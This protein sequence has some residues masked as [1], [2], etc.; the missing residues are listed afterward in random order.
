MVHRV[1]DGQTIV[2]TGAG[3]GIGGGGLLAAAEGARVVVTI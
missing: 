3:R 2:V 1:P